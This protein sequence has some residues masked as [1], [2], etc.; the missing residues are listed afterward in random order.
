MSE[1]S[2]FERIVEW[3]NLALEPIR[4]NSHQ[5]TEMLKLVQQRFLELDRRIA[6]LEAMNEAA[7]KGLRPI[8]C[9]GAYVD[10][11]ILF[12]GKL[13]RLSDG[14]TAWI[15]KDDGVVVSHPFSRCRFMDRE[16]GSAETDGW[17]DRSRGGLVMNDQLFEI[18]RKHEQVNPHQL[19]HSNIHPEDWYEDVRFLLELILSEPSN[20]EGV[21]TQ[22]ISAH[23][24]KCSRIVIFRD[25]TN[26]ESMSGVMNDKYWSTILYNAKW[27]YWDEDVEEHVSDKYREGWHCQQ[28]NEKYLFPS[29]NIQEEWES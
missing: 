6:S 22:I 23:C 17:A 11:K 2:E 12:T 19:E 8:A 21:V 7:H 28:C 18:R 25:T 1:K 27:R 24:R 20:N 14:V 16:K 29:E 10:D 15:E 26:T 3:L 9:Y 5:E 13:H 4:K